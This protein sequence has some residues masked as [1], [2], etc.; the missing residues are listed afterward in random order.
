MLMDKGLDEMLLWIKGI[1]K[2]NII[3]IFQEYFIDVVLND[4][5]QQCRNL[6]SLALS[7]FHESTQQVCTTY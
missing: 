3:I 2:F 7:L 1:D 5:N 4:A 6:A